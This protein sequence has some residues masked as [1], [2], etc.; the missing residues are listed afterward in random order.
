[1]NVTAQYPI[2]PLA[3]A[4]NPSTAQAFVD[5]VQSAEAQKILASYGFGGE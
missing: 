5:F 1:V 3:A 2:A 4:A